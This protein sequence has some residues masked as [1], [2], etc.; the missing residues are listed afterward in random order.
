VLA[1][2]LAANDTGLLSVG[3]IANDLFVALKDLDAV[4]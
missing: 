4:T 1:A 3:D 2:Y